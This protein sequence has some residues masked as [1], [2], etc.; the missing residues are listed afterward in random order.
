MKNLFELYEVI[1]GWHTFGVVFLALTEVIVNTGGFAM[2][3]FKFIRSITSFIKVVVLI[4]FYQRLGNACKLR[5]CSVM[6]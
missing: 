3:D 6:V 4:L 5:Y 1:G 2:E